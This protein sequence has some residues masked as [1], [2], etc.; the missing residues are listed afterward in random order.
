MTALTIVSVVLLGFAPQ[1]SIPAVTS[2]EPSSGLQGSTVRVTISG[3]NFPTAATIVVSHKDVIV[4]SV[5]AVNPS[6]MSALLVLGAP[7][8][9]EIAVTTPTGTSNSKA[10]TIGPN[11]LGSAYRLRSTR[12]WE[13]SEQH[14]LDGVGLQAR[15]NQPTGVWGVGDSLYVSDTGN[16]SIRRI[17]IQSRSV[18]TIAGSGKQGFTDGTG[19]DAEFTHPT[20]IW[21]SNGTLYIADGPDGPDGPDNSQGC[22]RRLELDTRAVTTFVGHCKAQSPVI[23]DGDRTGAGLGEI[24]QIWGDGEYLYLADRAGGIRRVELRT[25]RVVTLVL[26]PGSPIPKNWPLARA[27][28]G[29]GTSLYVGYGNTVYRINLSTL[30]ATR[31]VAF[32]SASGALRFVRSIF[33]DGRNLFVT[34]DSEPG[35]VEIALDTGQV[36]TIGGSDLARFSG[37]WGLWGDGENL[38]VSDQGSSVIRWFETQNGE[39]ATLAGKTH[40][41]SGDFE[42]CPLGPHL[43]PAIWGDDENLYVAGAFGHAIGAINLATGQMTTIAGSSEFPGSADGVGAAARFSAPSG[44]WG[45]AANLYV[46]DTGNHTIR[47]IKI[48]TG[49]VSTIAGSPGESGRLD[50]IGPRARFLEPASLWSD[51]TNLYIADLSSESAAIRRL[52]LPTGAVT[53]LPFNKPTLAECRGG[54]DSTWHAL[55]GDGQ[56]LYFPASGTEPTNCSQGFVHWLDLTTG[57]LSTFKTLPYSGDYRPYGIWS[58][59]VYLY[60]AV[61][62]L[63]QGSS[64]ILKI[65][66]DD[67][68]VTA[69][70]GFPAVPGL[71]GVNLKSAFAYGIWGN[72]NAIY[73]VTRGETWGVERLEPEESAPPVLLSITPTEINP[74]STILATLS[75]LDLTSDYNVPPAE[76]PSIEAGDPAI[77]FENPFPIGLSL[78]SVRISV[79][80]SAP[81]GDRVLYVVTSAGRSN[82]LRLRINAISARFPEAPAYGAAISVQTISD[83]AV[84]PVAGYAKVEPD[85]NP[86]AAAAAIVSYRQNGILVSEAA[87]T[88]QDSLRD[89]RIYVESDRSFKTGIAMANPNG[90][91]AIVDFYFT[92]TAGTAMR[93]RQTTIPANGQIVAFLDEQPFAGQSPFRGT[94]TFSSS[95]DLY[96]SA[97]RAHINERSEFLMTPLPVMP[98][99]SRSA[100]G[101]QFIPH[102][103]DGGGWTTQILLVNP[104]SAAIRGKIQFFSQGT[105]SADGEPVVMELDGKTGTAFDYVI[106]ANASQRVDTS[107]SPAEPRVGSVRIMPDSGSYFPSSLAIFSF[108]RDGITVN[109]TGLEGSFPQYYTFKADWVGDFAAR[110]P[111]SMRT[112]IVVTNTHNTPIRSYVAD[113]ER[114]IPANGQAAFFLDKP[115]DS[116]GIVRVVG[117]PAVAGSLRGR[118]NDRGDLIFTALPSFP[119]PF[120]SRTFFPLVVNGGG[121]S[122]EFVFVNECGP[123]PLCSGGAVKVFSQSGDVVKTPV[124]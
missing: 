24:G 89:G 106:P 33:G 82:P 17:E 74:G 77:R 93:D 86:D 44:I 121:F 98:L 117:D 91:P 83:P 30:V 123:P 99:S 39:V 62:F 78:L 104:T 115:P 61:Q 75:G 57:A 31:L 45:D 20:G 81:S 47:R 116:S 122:T 103:A 105:P 73:V 110:E 25:G 69:A 10:F 38:Y 59:G 27:I 71:N 79:D 96:V 113:I 76:I 50:D 66:L 101:I 63:D 34:L 90:R 68:V 7:G 87:F 85:N 15:L 118:Y 11:A 16:A 92:D 124:Q 41:A 64:E 36:T 19:A 53:T 46:A 8:V 42:C 58:D 13:I 54:D 9:V 114:I 35:V 37:P 51:G 94:L 14:F 108:K 55:W 21:G 65:R 1:T 111:G 67:G 18:T 29:D 22:I 100:G 97:I 84:A 70:A 56:Y 109:E 72:G 80:A 2:V 102:F 4:T 12:R 28:W 119:G 40:N 6:T 107:G 49:E 60:V 5:E 43:S 88:P 112:A 32:D 48:A 52:N 120:P 3:S 23:V 95:Q 26:S